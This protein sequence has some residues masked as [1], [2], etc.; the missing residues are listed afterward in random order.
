MT[1]KGYIKVYRQIVDTAIWADSDKLK[2]WMM[3]ILKASHEDHDVMVGNTIIHLEKGEFLT[4]RDALECEFNKGV[5]R[6]KRVS[7]KTLFRYLEMFEKLKMLSIKKSNKY[8]VISLI[9]WGKYQSFNNGNVQELSQS[10]PASVPIVSTNNNVNNIYT[11]ARAR[12]ELFDKVENL[13]CR[14]L[15]Q[16][17]FM[18]TADIADTYGEDNTIAAVKLAEKQNGRSISYLE[19]ILRNQ[20]SKKT[21]VKKEGAWNEY[22]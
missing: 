21:P 15:S 12:E 14:P 4:G 16:M 19:T 6:E 2:L 8:T 5:K 17:E 13:L 18:R 11:R 9:N 20:R 7:G 3:C 22:E 10:C 1:R